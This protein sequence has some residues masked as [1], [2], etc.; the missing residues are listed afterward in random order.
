M[1][2]CTHSIRIGQ[3]LGPGSDVSARPADSV[4]DLR[5]Q[6]LDRC[7]LPTIQIAVTET[8]TVVRIDNFQSPSGNCSLARYRGDLLAD[9]PSE[10]SLRL[11]GTP[12]LRLP[13]Q[14]MFQLLIESC[15]R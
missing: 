15:R 2:N 6:L 1:P 5:E 4:S 9:I 11:T 10:F 13:G 12:G 7:L 8:N 14:Q 3:S